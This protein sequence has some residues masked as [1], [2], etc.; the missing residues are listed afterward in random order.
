MYKDMLLLA[1]CAFVLSLILGFLL[2]PVLRR[3]KAGQTERDDGPKSHQAKTGTPIMGGLI[4]LIAA[5]AV[6]L[7]TFKDYPDTLPVL[8]LTWGF[9]AVGFIDDFIKA[10]LKRSM[11]LRAWQKMLLQICVSL[12]FVLF[13]YFKP[14][15]AFE[16]YI[17]FAGAKKVSAGVFAVPAAVFIIVG[18]V[19][20]SNFT[21]GVDGLE[22]SVTVWIMA[23][24]AVASVLSLKNVTSLPVIFIGALA[25]FLVFNTNKA[26]VF[27]GDTGSLALGG[28]VSGLAYMLHLELYIPIIALI[29]FAE[30]LSV[31]LQVLYFKATHGKRIFKMA[32]IHHHFELSGWSEAKVVYIFSLVTALLCAFSLALLPF[33]SN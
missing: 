30:V 26:K 20:G 18:T 14:D 9:A 31:I 1:G 22:S 2:I 27:M 28:L 10:V 4:F 15:Y 12:A 17:P 5:T 3:I 11:G 6:A 21:D 32:P 33:W 23:F 8:L 19:N 7:F 24:F 25:G 16:A 29:Y 13:L